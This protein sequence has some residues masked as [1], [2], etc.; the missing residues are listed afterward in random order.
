MLRIKLNV[1]NK[2]SRI[3]TEGNDGLKDSTAS[4]C[5]D[6]ALD[7]FQLDADSTKFNLSVARNSSFLHQC[8]IT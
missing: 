6:R 7:V 1:G 2:E 4:G 5:D 8:S 3:S